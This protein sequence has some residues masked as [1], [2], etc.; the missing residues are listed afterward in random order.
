[1]ILTKNG[2]YN[3]FDYTVMFFVKNLQDL[4]MCGLVKILI[5]NYTLPEIRSFR[6]IIF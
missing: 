3:T 6:E 2:K 5:T 1:M 4:T